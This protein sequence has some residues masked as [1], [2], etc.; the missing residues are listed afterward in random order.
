MA[1]LQD[2]G[3]WKNL[4]HQ[5]ASVWPRRKGVL[6]LQ[7]ELGE[8]DDCDV[9]TPTVCRRICELSDPYAPGTSVTYEGGDIRLTQHVVIFC[10]LPCQKLLDGLGHKEIWL[11][12]LGAD[13]LVA[14]ARWEFPS[15]PPSSRPAAG[16]CGSV[17]NPFGLRPLGGTPFPGI[18]EWMRETMDLP[19]TNWSPGMLAVPALHD[20]CREAYFKATLHRYVPY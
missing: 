15:Q 16:L 8:A 12:R 5:L 10:N 20:M 13:A 2:A 7:L 4:L 3:G 6:A 19:M 1:E 9:L 17:F 18:I 11:L 14:P